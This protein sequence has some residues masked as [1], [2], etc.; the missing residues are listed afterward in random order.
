MN[1][2]NRITP[3]TEQDTA[4]QHIKSLLAKNGYRK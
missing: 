2:P 4:R 3:Q 1:T